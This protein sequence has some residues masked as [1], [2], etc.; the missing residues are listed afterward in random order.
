M[1]AP[2]TLT[3]KPPRT[4]GAGAQTAMWASFGVTLFGPLTGALVT[5]RWVHWARPAACAPT[6]LAGALLPARLA[7]APTP[8]RC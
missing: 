6:P 8:A 5:H 1:E 4:L 3:D 2:L 7:S